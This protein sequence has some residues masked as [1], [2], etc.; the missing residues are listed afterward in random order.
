MFH[1]TATTES[2][3]APKGAPKKDRAHALV[4]TVPFWQWT[5][6]W[7]AQ[8]AYDGEKL[9]LAVKKY[10]EDQNCSNGYGKCKELLTKLAT[11]AFSGDGKDLVQANHYSV[12]Y[13]GCK[14]EKLD[15]HK[16]RPPSK[17]L[18]DGKSVSVSTVDSTF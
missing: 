13:C 17:S 16:K 7:F 12:Y 3:Q 2:L 4:R 15:T 18:T 8:N 14:W 10:C 9:G 6:S 5:K 11:D 1:F